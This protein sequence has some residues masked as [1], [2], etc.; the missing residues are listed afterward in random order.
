MHFAELAA[1]QMLSSG[2]EFK[3]AA[4][5]KDIDYRSSH[6]QLAQLIAECCK[7]DEWRN[8]I[9][10]V[11]VVPSLIGLVESDDE[12]NCYQSLRAL[13]NLCYESPTGRQCIASNGATEKLISI[14]SSSTAKPNINMLQ[15]SL[16][17]LLNYIN[18]CG[19][20]EMIAHNAGNLLLFLLCDYQYHAIQESVIETIM[21]LIEDDD[22]QRQI[23][24]DERINNMISKIEQIVNDDDTDEETIDNVVAIIVHLLG[25]NYSM[26]IMFN[27]GTGKIVPILLGWL[28]DKRVNLKAAA[29]LGIGNIARSDSN[30]KKLTDF[31]IIPNLLES[32]KP[33][34]DTD[35]NS[36]LA[37]AALSA[38]KNLSICSSV[39]PKL[40]NEGSINSISSL[41]SSL[42]SPTIYKSLSILRLLATGND[43]V[44]NQ[45]GSSTEIL[46]R[47]VELCNVLE[48]EGV[49]SEALR[50]LACIIKETQNKNIITNIAAIGGIDHI[51]SM[52]HNQHTQLQNEGAVALLITSAVADECL[53]QSLHEAGI[54]KE[55]VKVV[56]DSNVIAEVRCNLLSLI[57]ML[58]KVEPHHSNLKLAGVEEAIHCLRENDSE[59]VK[60]KAKDVVNNCSLG[61]A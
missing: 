28:R 3:I 59:L 35:R 50:L 54:V 36:K 34:E 20:K 45:L 60:A 48:H 22:F 41:L 17:C 1:E 51:I 30:C 29:C 12:K 4:Y 40:I 5:L 58:W 49:S 32:V 18:D 14:V 10:K 19:I 56:Q 57:E 26:K 11:Q 39:R 37:I 46:T 6:G 31:E 61:D 53:H 24:E 23:S 55:V 25:G 44:A 8:R 33:I 47:I 9:A 13:G 42:F 43:T 21:E 16:G 7:H 52:L 2:I 38:I 27:N 15:V